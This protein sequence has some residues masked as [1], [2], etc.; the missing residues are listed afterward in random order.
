M[1]AIAND[2]TTARLADSTSRAVET[3]RPGALLRLE[4]FGLLVLCGALYGS[5]GGGWG[6]FAALF[7][8]PDVS[9]AFWLLN[10]RIGAR[11]Y[12]S[13]HSLIGPLTLGVGALLTGSEQGILLGLIWAAHIGFDRAL[14]YGLKYGTEFRDTHLGRL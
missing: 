12:N 9:L 5:L 10:P 7:L 11:A 4:G 3:S 1:N 6:M 8:L 2:P 14:G 13:A